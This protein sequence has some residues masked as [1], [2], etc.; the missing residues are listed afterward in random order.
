MHSLPKPIFFFKDPFRCVLGLPVQPHEAGILT[1]KAKLTAD[2][3]D[4]D[5]PRFGGLKSLKANYDG[6]VILLYD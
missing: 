5:I 6:F 2:S 4:M 3:G 1:S